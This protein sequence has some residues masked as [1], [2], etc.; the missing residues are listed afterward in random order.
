M[1][2]AKLKRRYSHCMAKKREWAERAEQVAVAYTVLRRASHRRKL[3]RK[4]TLVG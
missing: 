2:L 3:T 1:S 4:T